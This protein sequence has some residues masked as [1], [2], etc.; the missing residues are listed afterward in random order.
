MWK[1]KFKVEQFRDGKLVN[2]FNVQNTIVDEGAEHGLNS[3]FGL[4]SQVVTWHIGL[5]GSASFVRVLA[6]DTIASHVGWVECVGYDEIVRSDFMPDIADNRIIQSGAATL[7][8][9]NV[10]T[11]LKGLFVVS[12]NVKNGVAGVLWAAALQD[13]DAI[14]GDQLRVSYR[15]EA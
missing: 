11:K 15:V 7:F 3:I 5:I 8:T 2:K 14:A 6:I 9:M 13:M 12:N 1:G 10:T 4:V